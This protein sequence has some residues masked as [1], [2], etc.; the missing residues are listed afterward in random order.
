MTSGESDNT[1]TTLSQT[2]AP[3][4]WLLV[5]IVALAIGTFIAM[6]AIVHSLDVFERGNWRDYIWA[7][8][9]V[10]LTASP[11]LSGG[12]VFG[13]LLTALYYLK[14]LFPRFVVPLMPSLALGARVH[15]VVAGEWLTR[16]M[17]AA[18][19]RVGLVARTTAREWYDANILPEA[20][21]AAHWTGPTFADGYYSAR[22]SWNLA[23]HKGDWYIERRFQYRLITEPRLPYPNLT[24]QHQATH[25][26]LMS[27]FPLVKEFVGHTM[28]VDGMHIWVY[29]VSS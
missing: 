28:K 4:K 26:E 21:A 8:S 5:G 20:K 3:T 25:R 18:R 7:G 10:G 9:W 23:E 13:A 19:E 6:L 17:S 11:K 29:Q 22:R 2:L 16:R 14:Q 24:V 15:S 1:H 12:V 27:R